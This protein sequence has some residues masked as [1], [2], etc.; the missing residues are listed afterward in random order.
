MNQEV[1]SAVYKPVGLIRA[2]NDES[3]KDEL[4]DLVQ[5][6]NDVVVDLE[7]V[8][9][10]D[11]SGIGLL[12][13]T[14]NSLKEKGGSLKVINTPEKILTM[15]KIMRLDRHFSIEGLKQ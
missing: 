8:T 4:L 2:A 12:I 14:H 13:A 5:S 11:S 7:D 6:T 9:L 15:F 1:E 3:L 10:I